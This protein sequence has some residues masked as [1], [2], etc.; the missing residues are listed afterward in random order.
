[1]CEKII[2]REAIL[3]WAKILAAICVLT[4]ILCLCM[5]WALLPGYWVGSLLSGADEHGLPTSLVEEARKDFGP[6]LLQKCW[7]KDP[8]GTFGSRDETL[9]M[10]G[11]F[12]TT[13]RLCLIIAVQWITLCLVI[14]RW[15]I[16]SQ[17]HALDDEQEL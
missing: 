4:V 11:R 9:R 3:R 10:W 12:E 16:S 7:I 5:R 6:I 17:H 8:E 13:H 15:W 14:A 2:M 1:M